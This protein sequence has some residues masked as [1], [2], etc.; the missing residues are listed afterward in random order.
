MKS[1]P[2]L[3]MCHTR[4]INT[5]NNQQT[6]NE[7]INY[8]GNVSQ[9]VTTNSG[10]AKTV[11]VALGQAKASKVMYLGGLTKPSLLY[12]AKQDLYK[13]VVL[14]KGQYLANFTIEYKYSN[15]I[16]VQNTLA[17]VHAE[18][19]DTTNLYPI[20]YDVL[21]YRDYSLGDTIYTADRFT[22]GVVSDF[23]LNKLVYKKLNGKKKKVKYDDC[24]VAK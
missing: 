6:K 14:K 2:T 11:G 3:S 1:L 24:F 10:K 13:N 17:Q 23:T 12:K 5:V 7:T 19:I 4:K 8:F 21:K 16:F 9:N 18:I 15:F 22:K 20:S